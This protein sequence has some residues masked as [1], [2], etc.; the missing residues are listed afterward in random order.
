M[1][2]GGEEEIREKMLVKPNAY[3]TCKTDTD[4]ARE[5]Y[6]R[7]KGRVL[8]PDR[9]RLNTA[10]VVALFSET[11][12]LSNIFYATRLKKPGVDAEKALVYWLNTTWGLLSVVANREETEGLWMQLKMAQWRMLPV[13][14]VSKLDDETLKRL[15]NAFDTLCDAKPRRI[16]EQFSTDPEKVDPVRLRFDL[17]FLKALKPDIDENEAKKKLYEIYKRIAVALKQWTKEIN[18]DAQQ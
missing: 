13:L 10:H 17:E 1:I 4:K 7:F 3:A 5:I 16:V 18:K 6:K 9:I 8:L 2:Y 15:S 12:V 11:P 14:D